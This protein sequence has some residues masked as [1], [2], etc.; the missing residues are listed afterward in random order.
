MSCKLDPAAGVAPAGISS[1]ARCRDFAVCP[2]VKRLCALSK[3]RSQMKKSRKVFSCAF[4]IALF[5]LP[6]TD[7]FSI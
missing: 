3:E 5:T 7:Y 6:Q 4:I 2:A 1:A